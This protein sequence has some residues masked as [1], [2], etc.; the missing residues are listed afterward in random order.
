MIK[1]VDDKFSAYD[2]FLESPSSGALKVE[3]LEIFKTKGA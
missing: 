3:I 2:A 1:N